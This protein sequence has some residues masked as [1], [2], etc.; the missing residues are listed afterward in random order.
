MSYQH[1]QVN[2]FEDDSKQ[3]K[4]SRTNHDANVT[5]ES[6]LD[7]MSFYPNTTTP[8]IATHYQEQQQQVPISSYQ[9]EPNTVETRLQQQLRE[10]Y[11]VIQQDQG[12]S[13]NSDY[14]K[15]PTSTGAYSSNGNIPR[16]AVPP[17]IHSYTTYSTD[18]LP[19]VAQ[20]GLPE[21]IFRLR[22]INIV[23][24]TLAILSG[25]L[26]LIGYLLTFRFREF[27]MCAYLAFM[28]GLLCC[29]EAHTPVVSNVLQDSFGFI[30]D[31]RLRCVFLFLLGTVSCQE[32][33]PFGIV[34]GFTFIA[35]SLY[36]I[37]VLQKYGTM[38]VNEQEKSA[39]R[40]DITAIAGRAGFGAAFR[41]PA[42]TSI[43]NNNANV[44]SYVDREV[45]SLINQQGDYTPVQ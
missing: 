6:N 32:G 41:Q 26:S 23:L 18:P 33:S 45:Q 11:N 5:Q 1:Q 31:H 20:I 10:S 19:T 28:S 34:L 29:F 17:A 2:P 16:P 15:P 38:V 14:N 30:Y 12:H 42:W 35:N 40:E 25:S 39:G 22:I 8:P 4:N 7:A 13:S 24:A 36:N 21:I 37:Y 43:G 9:N 3:K 44:Q 27:V